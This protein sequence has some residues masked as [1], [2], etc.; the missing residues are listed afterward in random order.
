[1]PDFV[2]AQYVLLQLLRSFGW[3]RKADLL[4]HNAIVEATVV[5][6]CVH[7]LIQ[8]GVS[9]G[10]GRPAL[11][12]RLLADTFQQRDWSG[13]SATE[14]LDSLDPNQRVVDNRNQQP[15]E[16]I[17]P[18]SLADLGRK[19]IP[20]EWLGDPRLAIHFTGAFG[21]ALIWGLLHPK[22]AENALNEQRFNYEQHA[23][24]WQAAGSKISSQYT[25]T[26]NEDFYKNCEEMVESFVS[27][28]RPL[29][30]TPKELLSEPRIVRRLGNSL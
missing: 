7:L 9:L 5:D 13:H 15:Y 4:G 20:W 18:T 1:M 11:A 27:E 25:W 16:A 21:Q 8:I 29:V 22:E 30:N 26:T 2:F 24:F 28:R 12:V 10:T 3:P 14:L 17:A 23:P 6:V 19:E